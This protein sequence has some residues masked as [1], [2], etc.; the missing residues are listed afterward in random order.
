MNLLN[1]TIQAYKYIYICMHLY[2][3]FTLYYFMCIYYKRLHYSCC[4]ITISSHPLVWPQW[5]CW[6][7][8]ELALG[9]DDLLI[10]NPAIDS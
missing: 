6:V 9:I 10:K 4:D 3:Y 8:V 2:V 5:Q 1:H 7:E